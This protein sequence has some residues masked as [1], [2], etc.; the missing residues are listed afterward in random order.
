MSVTLRVVHDTNLAGVEALARRLREKRELVG[1]PSGPKE[2]EGTSLAEVALW[3]EFGTSTAP[4]RPFMREGIRQGVPEMRRVA[5][6]DLAALAEG[7]G[8]METV[9]ARLGEIGAGAVKRY[10]VGDHFAPNAPATIAKKGS[11]QPTIDSATLRNG[12]THAP[13]NV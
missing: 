11:S 3:T 12:I 6:H 2:A 4:E 7:N 13:E 9:V 10:M 5:R 1:V 8:S